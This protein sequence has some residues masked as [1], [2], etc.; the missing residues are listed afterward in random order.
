LIRDIEIPVKMPIIVRTNNAVAMFMA[1][2]ASSDDR[3]R[4]IDTI[5]IVFVKTIDNN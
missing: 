1:E 3:T 4:H 5:E 2:N